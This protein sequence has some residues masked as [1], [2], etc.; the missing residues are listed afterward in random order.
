MPM[1]FSERSGL[2]SATRCMGWVALGTLILD[3]GSKSVV[4]RTMRLGQELDVIRGFFR[5]VHWQ[6]SGAA[7][8]MFHGRN[9]ILA[10]VSILALVALY[11]GRRHFES[12]T[13]P[14]QWALGLLFGG[15]IGNLID[16]LQLDHVVDF[17]YFH[18]QRRGGAEIGFPAFNVADTAISCGVF[19]LF[20][21]SW[22]QKDVP[23]ARSGRA[24]APRGGT[25]AGTIPEGGQPNP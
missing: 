3:Q 25:V 5:F 8:S 2:D 21:L 6:N 9:Q 20:W 16:R 12:H 15:I 4:L 17:L 10:G 23:A 22:Q 13:R 14:G 19:I 7:W 11:L 18:L 24:V 1:D